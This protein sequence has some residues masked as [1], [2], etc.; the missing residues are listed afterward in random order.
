MAKSKETTED[1]SPKPEE[2]SREFKER[3][4]LIEKDGQLSKIKHEQTMKELEY[5]R[6]SDRLHHERELERGRIFRAEERKTVLLKSQEF[7]NRDRDRDRR[8][9]STEPKYPETNYPQ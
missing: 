4:Q 3:T 9:R 1:S 2:S 8:P 7:R 6:E 5:R